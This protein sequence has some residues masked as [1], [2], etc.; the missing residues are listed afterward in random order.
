MSREPIVI[1]GA[2]QSAAVAAQTLRE[3]AHRGRIVMLGQEA[4]RPYER[5]PL[6]KAVLSAEVE[7]RLDVLPESVLSHID[8]ELL[9]NVEVVALDPERQEVRARDGRVFAYG[10][11]L[12]ATG[13]EAMTMAGLPRGT[14]RVHYIRTLDDARRFRAALGER[15]RIAIIGGGFLGLELAHSALAAGASS[16]ALLARTPPLLER[17][18]P[19][20]AS[21]WLAS[22]LAREG[23]RLVLDDSLVHARAAENGCMELVTAAGLRLEADQIVVAIGLVP[24]DQLARDA[25]LGIADGGGVLV[26]AECRTTD[27]FVFAVGDCASQLRRGQPRPTRVE[28]WQNANEQARAAAAAILGLRPPPPVVPWFWTDQGRHNLQVLGAPASDLQYLRCGDPLHDKALWIGHRD[29][30]PI[31][32]VALNCGA[33]LRAIR[34]LFDRAQPVD[35]SDLSHEIV[36]LRAW[37]RQALQRLPVAA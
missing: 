19:S 8:V 11:C 21:A 36:N 23:V 4:H 26:D 16:V 7:P 24:N 29:G 1:V 33:E 17:F 32:G 34:P 18:L 28:S 13:G 12:L 9:P 25:G 27:P 3:F 6:S 5:P 30:V 31:H 14:P 37:A 22:A 15:P 35:V 20:E 10:T 2:G